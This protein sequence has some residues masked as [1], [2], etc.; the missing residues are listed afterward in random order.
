LLENEESSTQQEM[1]EIGNAY[2][3]SVEKPGDDCG[4][5]T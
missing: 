3:V 1:E 5:K 4:T 2:Q